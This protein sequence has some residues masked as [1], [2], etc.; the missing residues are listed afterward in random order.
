[1][2][3][4]DRKRRILERRRGKLL[5]RSSSVPS[6]LGSPN[7]KHKQVSRAA[8]VE[9]SMFSHIGRHQSGPEASSRSHLYSDDE[10]DVRDSQSTVQTRLFSNAD[11]HSGAATT[12]NFAS[13]LVATET[14]QQA[15]QSGESSTSST[16]RTSS[17]FGRV[18]QRTATTPAGTGAFATTPHK[19]LKRHATEPTTPSQ[20]MAKHLASP[21]GYGLLQMINIASPFVGKEETKPSPVKEDEWQEAPMD[22]ILDWT[23]KPKLRLECNPIMC[24]PTMDAEG[25]DEWNKA[26][27]YWQYRGGDNDENRA[28]SK[29]SDV[30]KRLVQA[31]R[32][33]NA[34]IREMSESPTRQ[35]QQAFNGLY[36]LWMN[37]LDRGDADA[38]FYAT[39]TNQTILFRGT[40][41]GEVQPM[42]CLS[43]TT[44][45]L[46]DRLARR[47]V[48][49]YI[50]GTRDVFDEAS[51]DPKPKGEPTDQQEVNTDMEA[52]RQA[53]VFG[54]TAGADVSIK[55]TNKR[56]RHVDIPPLYIVGHDDCGSFCTWFLNHKANSQ[57]T[58]YTRMGAFPNA[59]LR[60]L[61]I[62][63]Q[64]ITSEHAFVELAGLI[65]PCAIPALARV[66]AETMLRHADTAQGN[67]K[68][69]SKDGEE[70]NGLGSHYFVLQA[71]DEP[72][73]LVRGG[74]LLS[75]ISLNGAMDP[76]DI[77]LRGAKAD[78]V[79]W[80]ITRPGAMTYK[81][82][83]VAV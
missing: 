27:Q 9:S 76:K 57:P 35:W 11:S 41:R 67:L 83:P 24:L 60:S 6:M 50:L 43:S 81:V 4:Q 18:M 25:L 55:T 31:V 66:T 20:R 58:L 33:Q 52:L 36:R 10:G 3:A 45:D 59:T 77:C 70:D 79:V 42:V 47:G 12:T 15:L 51:Y 30:A 23:I 75:P 65:F 68:E 56:Q 82:D 37:R 62:A 32:G 39:C 38:Y 40:V 73:L 63:K 29:G 14:Q 22:K 74:E 61:A 28:P 48:T 80:D 2:T 21:G 49:L 72:E 53:Q 7:Y 5:Q 19:K 69:G 71:Q 44:K 54:A 26:L 1:M 16:T 64:R 13:R 78:I 34:Y 46:R 8:A 17:L